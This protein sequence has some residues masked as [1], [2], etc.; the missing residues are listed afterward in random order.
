MR[1]D[2]ASSGRALP[3]YAAFVHFGGPL[4]T[5]FLQLDKEIEVFAEQFMMTVNSATGAQI[6]HGINDGLSDRLGRIEQQAIELRDA[7]AGGMKLCRDEL[8]KELI[9][10]EA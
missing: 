1:L 2:S 7:A 9:K 5:Q 3:N 10:L 4:T 6:P 8:A